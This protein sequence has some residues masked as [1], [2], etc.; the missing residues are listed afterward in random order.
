MKMKNL[1]T[2]ISATIMVLAAIILLILPSGLSAQAN[3]KLLPGA[4]VNIKVLGSSNVHDWTMVSSIMESQA[5]LSSET[6]ISLS[7]SIR[8]VF[9]WKPKA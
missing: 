1:N 4:D 9:G 7:P 8:S 6:K 3:Y 2:R 5:I